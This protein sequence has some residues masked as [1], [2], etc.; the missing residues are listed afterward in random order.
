MS[1]LQNPEDDTEVVPPYCKDRLLE[2]RASSRPF[3]LGVLQKP[4]E[5]NH[6]R[7][8]NLCLGGAGVGSFALIDSSRKGLRRQRSQN[9]FDRDLCATCLVISGTVVQGERAIPV[10]QKPVLKNDIG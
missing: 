3:S 2:G 10:L 7:L 8:E 1:L 5:S 4:H 6:L 9:V